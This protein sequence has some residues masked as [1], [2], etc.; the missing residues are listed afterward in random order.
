MALHLDALV[1]HVTEHNYVAYGLKK[2]ARSISRRD[3]ESFVMLEVLYMSV[4]STVPYNFHSF[5]AR[6][7][8]GFDRYPR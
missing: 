8:G 4:Y 7:R 1:K 6:G 3:L 2:L 5:R